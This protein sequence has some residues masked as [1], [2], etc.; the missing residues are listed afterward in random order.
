MPQFAPVEKR[1]TVITLSRLMVALLAL[2]ICGVGAAALFSRHSLLV[3]VFAPREETMARR[4]D[5]AIGATVEPLDPATARSLGLT[6]GTRGAVVTSI[7]NEGPAA[8]AGVRTGDV[9]VAIDRPV[10]S[11]ND[12][13]TGLRNNGNVLTVTLNR[14]GQSVIVPLAVGAPDGE[15]A[16]FKEEE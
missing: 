16:L 15:R 12:L 7:A 1:P 2:L 8:H 5:E 6:A 3:P 13:A 11:V 4:L 14:R 9:I 10:D